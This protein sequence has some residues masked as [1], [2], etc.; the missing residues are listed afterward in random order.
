MQVIKNATIVFTPDT[1][2]P[3]EVKSDDVGQFS[4]FLPSG[5]TYSVAVAA[6]GFFVVHR[7][8]FRMREGMKLK[9]DFMVTVFEIHDSEG[10]APPG[11]YSG[12][13]EKQVEFGSEAAIIISGHRKEN[14]EQIQYHSLLARENPL[15]VTISFDTYTIKAERAVL[16]RRSN[17]LTAEGHVSI[18]DGSEKPPQKLSCIVL[19]TVDNAPKIEPCQAVTT[20]INP[21]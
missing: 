7:P 3:V 20:T 5:K 15:P 10:T 21:K 17:V 4:V 6:P 13:A 11:E 12:F 19:R 14:E 16:D 1:G 2:G 9:F 18:E 8:P